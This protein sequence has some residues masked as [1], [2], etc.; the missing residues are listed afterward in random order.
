MYKYYAHIL[1][2]KLIDVSQCPYIG[3]DWVNIEVT[4]EIFENPAQYMYSEG[5]IVVNPDYEAEQGKKERER[6]D[7][8]SLTKREVFLALYKDK[9]ITPEVLKSQITDPAALIE[10]EYANDYYRGNPLIA[11]IGEQLGY[12]SDELDYLFEH[13]EFEVKPIEDDIKLDIKSKEDEVKPAEIIE[14]SEDENENDN[15]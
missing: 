11:L 13:G 10:F 3:D 14:E 9:G 12:T 7:M 2:D 1:N 4:S 6:L 5:E 15:G 8:L